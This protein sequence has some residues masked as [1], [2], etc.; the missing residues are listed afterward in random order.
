MGASEE[1][2]H[3]KDEAMGPMGLVGRPWWSAG[4]LGAP[5]A[6]KFGIWAALVSLV[7]ISWIMAYPKLVCSGAHASFDPFQP[8]SHALI[9]CAF[10]LDLWSVFPCS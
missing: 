9:G 8:D 10:C 2:P 5:T 3:V 4:L 6:P 1:P 7:P